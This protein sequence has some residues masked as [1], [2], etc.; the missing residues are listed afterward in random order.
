[1]VL[2]KKQML[3]VGRRFHG[4]NRANADR[5]MCKKCV[6]LDRRISDLRR[7]IAHLRDARTVEAANDMIAEMDAHKAAHHPQ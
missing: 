5:T 6:E 3:P 4:G 7:M 1:M 2:L